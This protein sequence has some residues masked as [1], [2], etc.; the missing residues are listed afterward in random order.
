MSVEPHER[1][2]GVGVFPSADHF[3]L[4]R[5][6]GRTDAEPAPA[7]EVRPFGLTLAV[8]PRK[9]IRFN[10]DELGYDE[11]GQIGLIREGDVMVPMSKHT[12]G[13]TKTQTNADGHGGRD[14]DTD[15]RED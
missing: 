15:F 12:D 11:V 7:S 9:N 2:N 8:Q 3:P 1:P 14:S 4:G 13:T 5:P 10:P 6:Y